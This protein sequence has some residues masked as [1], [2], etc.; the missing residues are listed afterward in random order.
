MTLELKLVTTVRERTAERD[1]EERYAEWHWPLVSLASLAP[2]LRCAALLRTCSVA[3]TRPPVSSTEHPTQRGCE[4]KSRQQTGQRRQL[5]QQQRDRVDRK[6]HSCSRSRR[7]R[8]DH[9]RKKSTERAQL[10]LLQLLAPSFESTNPSR[11][12]HPLQ[13]QP[14]PL[15]TSAP[16]ARPSRRKAR[17]VAA[18]SCPSLARKTTRVRSDGDV[19]GRMDRRSHAITRAGGGA[20][21]RQWAVQLTDLDAWCVLQSWE[22]GE[23]LNCPTNSN[24]QPI[25]LSQQDRTAL[26][27]DRQKQ[28]GRLVATMA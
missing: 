7:S 22:G 8:R 13:L 3:A 14:R 15:R 11:N 24:T 23:Y 5:R 27:A 9:T 2:C 17:P 12:R 25:F 28:R 6:P 16:S 10:R 19:G 26:Q 20:H 21:R 18:S 1:S 4:T